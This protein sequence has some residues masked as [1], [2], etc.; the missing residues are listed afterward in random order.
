MPAANVDC[1]QLEKYLKA[2]MWKTADQ[3]TRKLMYLACGA[4]PANRNMTPAVDQ[5]P[6]E[7]LQALDW[8]WMTYSKGRFGFS[9][10]RDI[11]EA[12][13]QKF[14]DKTDVWNAFGSRVGWRINHLL[15]QNYWKLQSELDSSLKAPVGH[16]PHM[17]KQF[18]ILTLE[19]LLNRLS[20]CNTALAESEQD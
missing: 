3:E 10:Q 11:W 14:L 9:A 20:Y 16:F 7:D 6:C 8:L 18:S 17:G 12:C 19:T 4:N 2:G 5:I 1:S 15:R 13:T